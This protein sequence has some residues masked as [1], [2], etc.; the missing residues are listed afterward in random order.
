VSNQHS[1]MP[2]VEQWTVD[3]PERPATSERLGMKVLRRIEQVLLVVGLIFFIVYGC[4]RTHAALFSQAAMWSFRESRSISPASEDTRARRKVDFSIWSSKRV[5]AYSQA[6]A[7]KFTPLAVLSIPRLGIHV[8]VFEGTDELSLNRGAGLIAGTV[9]PGE[10]G[11]VGIAAHRDGFFRGLKDVKLGDRVELD[12]SYG[13]Q[14]YTVDNITIVKPSDVSVLKRSS[15][16][17]L[18]LVTCYPFYFVG[19][20]QQRYIVRASLVDSAKAISEIHQEFPKPIFLKS[21]KERA[22]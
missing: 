9:S 1:A 17:S 2:G 7:G 19:D 15:E 12:L 22:Q 11:N 16:P 14:I 10:R 8:P 18:T 20:A 5:R 13:T 21:N 3:R 6:L 4:G